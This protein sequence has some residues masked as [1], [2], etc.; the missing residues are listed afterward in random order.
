[1]REQARGPLAQFL[2]GFFET[3]PVD[4][5]AFMRDLIAPDL[6]DQFCIDPARIY[7]NGMSN[8]GGMT[9]RLAC[10]LSDQIAAVAW[11]SGAYT[12]FPGGCH[13]TRPVP[14]MAFHGKEDPIVPY[15]GNPLIHFPPIEQWVADWAAARSMR[16]R[17]EDRHAE[18][19][20]A[21]SAR[22]IPAVRDGC[23][24]RFLLD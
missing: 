16:R 23:G 8:G 11:S 10:E 12:D 7:V 22:A 1:M 17:C 19:R 9:N 5:V 2:S 3:V 21:S 4:D 6:S 24:S 18:R 15:E 13:P 14:V 20:D